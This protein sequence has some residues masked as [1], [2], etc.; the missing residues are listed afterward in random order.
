MVLGHYA[1]AFVAK[2]LTPRTSLGTTVLAR[3]GSTGPGRFVWRRSEKQKAR[4][5]ILREVPNNVER[6]S[7][8]SALWNSALFG[9]QRRL[10]LSALRDSAPYGTSRRMGPRAVWDFAQFGTLRFQRPQFRA[11]RDRRIDARCFQL[12]RHGEPASIGSQRPPF[13]GLA[14][15]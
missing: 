9:T 2:R 12:T 13:T 11:Q 4:S 8:L 7:E 15:V 6:R 5:P 3:N 1:L 10:E 14:P